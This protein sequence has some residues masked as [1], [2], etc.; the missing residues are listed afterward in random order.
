MGGA[1]GLHEL[2]IFLATVFWRASDLI[3]RGADGLN[4]N[5]RRLG[6]DSNAV[7]FVVGEAQNVLSVHSAYIDCVQV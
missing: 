6:R 5:A 1:R 2:A 4:A 3:Y 7:E